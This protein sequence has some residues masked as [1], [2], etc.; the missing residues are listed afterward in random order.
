MI[1]LR[2][3]W[4]IGCASSR[5]RAKPKAFRILDEQLVLFRDEQ[6]V[7]HALVDR[8]RHRGA[9]LSQG[10]C[11]AGKIECPY[12]GWR[13]AGSG[14]C[15][16]IL[17][18]T[19]DQRMPSGIQVP[20]YP[21]VE[22]DGNIWI[23]MARDGE[24]PGTPPPG[25]PKFERYRWVQGSI[26][27]ACSFQDLLENVLDI[28]HPAFVHP[29]THPFWYSRKFM[30]FPEK[31]VELRVTENGIT[32]TAPPTNSGD[33]SIPEDIPLFGAWE[34]PDRVVTMGR[35]G[36]FEFASWMHFVPT[37][38]NSCRLE[39]THRNPF[40]FGPKLSWRKREPLLLRQDRVLLEAICSARQA[41]GPIPERSVA[42]DEIPLTIRR[43]LKLAADG[44]WE[45]KRE[46]LPKRR[47]IGARY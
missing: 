45:E 33:D 37:S 42:I 20:S 24:Q 27:H 22:L 31:Q 32:T 29:W 9:R 30:G 46:S 10:R 5:L 41:E 4:Y 39:Y 13:F 8:C 17:S 28:A 12:H 7:P 38:E 15:T 25:I 23:Y 1:G 19:R 44:L 18:L 35:V 16:E 36:S 26:D 2:G 3:Y 21:C 43:I 6:N 14:E 11:I 34:L 47:V 40:P